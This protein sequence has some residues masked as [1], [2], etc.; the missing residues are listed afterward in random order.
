LSSVLDRLFCL[1]ER[2]TTVSRE[3]LAGF[4][5]FLSMAYVLF[6]VPQ[7]LGDAGMPRESVFVATALAAAVGTLI[8]GL[9]ANFPVAQAPGMG[10]LAFFAYTVV[11][12]MQI[13]WPVALGAVF[14]SGSFFLFL[15]LTGLREAIIST[16]PEGIKYATTAGIGLFIA[17][18]GLRNGG[19]VTIAP[20]ANI[21]VLGELHRPEAFLTLFGLVMTLLLYAREVRGA[22]F[23]GMALTAAVGIYS[24][25]IAAPQGIGDVIG[26][27]PT[28][29]PTFLKLD[30]SGLWTHTASFLAIVLTIFFVDFFDATGTLLAVGEEAGLLEQGR[31]KGGGRALLSDASAILVGALLG[32]S[33]TTS[34]IESASGVAAGGRTGL[35]AVVVAF[36][37]LLSLFFAPLLSVITPFVTAPALI[38]VGVLMLRGVRKIHWE[39][40]DEAV[41]AFFTLLLMPLTTSIMNGIAAGVL[42]YPLLKLVRGKLHEVPL[43]LWFLGATFLLYFFFLVP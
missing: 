7:V 17:F 24:G 34:Y 11:G 28:I 29:A 26:A 18:I 13:P 10:L 9:Y 35:T 19:L 1:R 21:P 8:M 22:V 15:T 33:S 31:L 23:W 5:T 25:V 16:I 38:V 40:W 37:F 30:F 43:L 14:V 12:A 41:P 3:I 27:V 6:V 32:T 2:R 39:E 36:L 4:T 42:L 20:G